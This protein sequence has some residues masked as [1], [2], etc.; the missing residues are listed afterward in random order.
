MTDSS[1]TDLLI[2]QP[3]LVWSLAGGISILVIAGF[4][5]LFLSVRKKAQQKKSVQNTKQARQQS[6]ANEMS[7][8]LA[9]IG[10]VAEEKA[11]VTAK[12]KGQQ[13][14]VPTLTTANDVPSPETAVSGSFLPMDAN[15]AA[16]IENAVLDIDPIEGEALPEENE[17]EPV[18][19]EQNELAALFQADV[20]VDPH[21]Q[22][23]RDNLPAISID[24]LLANVRAV[25]QELQEK[26]NAGQL[27]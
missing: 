3:V 19:E 23:L 27:N 9:E 16:V 2:N 8:V 21:I 4:L 25:S 17:S 1:F 14:I 7:K 22:A 5:A 6:N 20:T 26:I 24:E 18:V 12:G 13:N 15:E 10:K 11:P